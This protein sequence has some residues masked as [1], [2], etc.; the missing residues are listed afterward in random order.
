MKHVVHLFGS[1]EP[2]AT[3]RTT[4]IR[5]AKRPL[6]TPLGQSV[7]VALAGGQVSVAI[8]T[9]SRLVWLAAG[10]AADLEELESWARTAF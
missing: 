2:H 3:S 9:R 7:A 8:E 4:R 1:T 10:Q 6:V 5:W